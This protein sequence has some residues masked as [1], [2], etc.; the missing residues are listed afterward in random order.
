MP[1]YEKKKADMLLRLAG[2][3][4]LGLAFVIGRHL[5]GA[6]D[7]RGKTTPLCYLLALVGMASASSGAALAV[8]GRHLFDQVALSARWTLRG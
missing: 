5:F 1:W 7:P 8:L 2:L 6:A 4:L 3:A